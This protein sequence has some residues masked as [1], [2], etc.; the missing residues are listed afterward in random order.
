MR[1][2]LIACCMVGCWFGDLCHNV[3]Q[4]MR[5]KFEGWFVCSFGILGHGE[6]C[7]IVI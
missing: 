5:L 1:G 7:G 3:S 4:F 2:Q 6:F